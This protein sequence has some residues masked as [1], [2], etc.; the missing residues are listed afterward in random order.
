MVLLFL[1]NK[2]YIEEEYP[3]DYV[4]INNQILIN[5]DIWKK[6]LVKINNNKIIIIIILIIKNK[7]I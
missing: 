7:I 3:I 1:L 6:Y 4:V 2:F 5:V